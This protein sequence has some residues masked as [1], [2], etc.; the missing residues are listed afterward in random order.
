MPG[1]DSPQLDLAA[2]SDRDASLDIA[3]WRALSPARRSNR[4]A[5]LAARS[6]RAGRPRQ[7]GRATAARAAPTPLD[8]LAD[9]GRRTAQ[10]PRPPPLSNVVAPSRCGEALPPRRT[11]GVDVEPTPAATRSPAGAAR[12]RSRRRSRGRRALAQ[13][14]RTRAA[15]R[16]GGGEQFQAGAGRPPRSLKKQY[17]AAGV[18]AWQRGGP[19]LY[20]DGQLLFVPGLGIDARARGC[21][22][23]SRSWRWPGASAPMDRRTPAAAGLGRF[24]AARI[25]RLCPGDSAARVR[26]TV[27]GTHRSQVRRHLDGLDRAHPQR[28]QA[29]R[30]MGPRRPPDGRRSVGDERR[31]E[32]PARPGQANCRRQQRRPSCC[33]NST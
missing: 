15:P 29:R 33:A 23:A 17:Q 4:L 12:S 10:L 6:G 26:L 2:T 19:L 32:P 13:A 11:S 28:R 3:A 1:R 20:S 25:P 21:R 8:A 5:G 30:Q 14:A 7:P 27:H 22:R 18:P 31:D 16:A 9:R 24:F